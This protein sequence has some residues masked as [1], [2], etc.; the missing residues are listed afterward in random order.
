MTRKSTKNTEYKPRIAQ[1]RTNLFALRDLPAGIG[2]PVRSVL[3]C[4]IRGLYF[5]FC[6]FRVY[7]WPFV[8]KKKRLPLAASYSSISGN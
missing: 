7:L 1:I 8:A 5:V 4:D 3:I 2:R 6:I